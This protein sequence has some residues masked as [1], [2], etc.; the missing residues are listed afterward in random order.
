MRLRPTGELQRH[1]L[2][3]AY[4]MLVLSKSRRNTDV[5][6]L[7]LPSECV[8]IVMIKIPTERTE[9]HADDDTMSMSFVRAVN[10]RLEGTD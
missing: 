4:H 5:F 3:S 6:L 2:I 7:S 1:P 10:S 9:S 8:Y